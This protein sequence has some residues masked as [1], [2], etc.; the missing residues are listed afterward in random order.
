MNRI[1]TKICGIT[2][3][4]DANAALEAGADAIGLNFY[5]KSKRYIDPSVALEIADAV[6]AKM[7]VVGVFV[8]S[9]MQNI[10][11]IAKRVGLSHIQLHGDEVPESIES[12]RRLIEGG[13]II[14]A[15]RIFDTDLATAQSE[16]DRWES[17]GTDMV[18]LDA[19][20]LAAFGGTGKQLDWNRLN[21]LSFKVP[22]LLAG[23]L[24]P[25]NVA[26]AIGLCQ[27]NGVDVAS[28]VE[29]SPGIK[30]LN[31]TREFVFAARAEMDS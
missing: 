8:N 24:M 5:E 6:K 30:D 3:V 16:I 17:A 25:E 2:R 9:P 20:S 12:L 29:I 14:R 27:P 15:I 26:A 22:W 19:A 10:S 21:E 23:G 1:R 11:E 28:G 31:Q 4:E 18:L 13:K 7:A